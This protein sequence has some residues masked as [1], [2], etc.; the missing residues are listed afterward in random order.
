[1]RVLKLLSAGQPVIA[2]F[3]THNL[4][5]QYPDH[6]YEWYWRQWEAQNKER[7]EKRDIRDYYRSWYVDCNKR[8]QYIPTPGDVV[9]H[10]HEELA[11][12]AQLKF[13]ILLPA[14]G[15]AAG[16]G[17]AT[18]FQEGPGD[19]AAE[20]DENCEVVAVRDMNDAGS[21]TLSCC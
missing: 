4:S 10:T 8:E 21:W 7:K 3:N 13:R 14:E 9:K 12:L 1:M 16:K 5:V 18:H 6:R 15:G 20:W 2:N 11:E 17:Q 19:V